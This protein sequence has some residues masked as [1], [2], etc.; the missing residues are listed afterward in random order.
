MVG[1]FMSLAVVIKM[2]SYRRSAS[3]M[4]HKKSMEGDAR[5]APS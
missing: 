5:N 4:T 2:M 3:D 1:M